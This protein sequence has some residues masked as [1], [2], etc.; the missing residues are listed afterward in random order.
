MY[1]KWPENEIDHINGIKDDNRINNLRD[2]TNR[3]NALN[4]GVFKNNKLI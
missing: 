2:V 1:G 3:Q 4:V